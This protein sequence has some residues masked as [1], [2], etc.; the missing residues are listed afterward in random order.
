MPGGRGRGRRRGRSR[1]VARL[2][3]P[4]LLLLLHQGLAHGYALL[5]Q[6]AE[7]GLAQVDPSVVY[8]VLRD[9]EERGWVS[10]TW[11]EEKTHGPP[12]RVYRL[13]AE[14]AQVL[15][16]WIQDLE[17]TRRIVDH[18]LETYRRHIEEGEGEH[19]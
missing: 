2:L 17:E 14:G 12:R 7:F 19:H 1:R 3:E 4:T 8:R 13:T 6:L 10:S 18:V 16:A 11:E 5:D 15:S 9:M